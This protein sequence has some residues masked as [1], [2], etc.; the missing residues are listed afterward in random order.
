MELD[1]K[2]KRECI[3]RG[4]TDRTIETYISCINKFLR[5][6]GKDA[7]YVSKQDA[8]DFLNYL[9]EK[10]LSGNSMNVYHMALRFLLEE[11]LRKN[12]HLNIKYSKRPSK[13]P[14]VLT[15]DETRKLIEAIKNQKHR[16]IIEL[17][18]S[19]GLRVSEL[20]NMRVCDLRIDKN[21]GFVRQGKGRKDRI[22]IIADCLKDKLRNLIAEEKL[23]DENNLF[24]TN[25]RE[26]YSARTL[27]EIIKTACKNSGINKKVHCH[28]LRHSFA[29]HLIENSCSLSEVQSL[30]GHKSPETTMIYVHLAAPNMIKVR[31]PLESL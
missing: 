18:Y 12:I 7:R 16:L 5:F 23:D 21:Y 29:T 8:L 4:F 15:K 13:L 10:G 20:T 17:I 2:I 28:T 24:L 31:S 19:A 1:E 25:K 26:R 30:L 14:I 3:R 27:A 11:V 6:C 9:S 22:F